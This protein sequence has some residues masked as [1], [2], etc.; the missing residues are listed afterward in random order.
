MAG[1]VKMIIHFLVW[2]Y[3]P[4]Y[5]P[6]EKRWQ[7]IWKLSQRQIMLELRDMDTK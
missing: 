1:N 4:G 6:D 5:V 3:H 7:K 2:K